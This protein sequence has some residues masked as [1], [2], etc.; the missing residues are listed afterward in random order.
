MQATCQ[1]LWVGHPGT[2]RLVGPSLAAPTVWQT[3]VWSSLH[4]PVYVSVD[5]RGHR[6]SALQGNDEP[7]EEVINISLYSTC[8]SRGEEE[9]T[10]IWISINFQCFRRQSQG[11]SIV[12]WG[13][14]Q[15]S[16]EFHL[17]IYLSYSANSHVCFW[18]FLYARRELLIAKSGEDG[19][20][21][22]WEEGLKLLWFFSN[23][24]TMEAKK[25]LWNFWNR[26]TM[27]LTG[28]L[29]V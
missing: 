1:V 18:R 21:L 8:N 28:P 29:E 10:S 15:K 26:L 19:W 25:G 27:S 14:L 3:V 6:E 2:K 20:M 22:V 5:H 16:R 7:E 9:N 24:N 17:C 11:S 12:K 13:L 23:V 4:L